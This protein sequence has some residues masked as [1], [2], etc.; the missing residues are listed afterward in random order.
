EGLRSAIRDLNPL[1]PTRIHRI[2][3]LARI[4]HDLRNP[5]RARNRFIHTLR[6]RHVH[7][8]GVA[9]AILAK[10]TRRTLD[11]VI[12]GRSERRKLD[13]TSV[14]AATRDFANVDGH[15]VRAVRVQDTLRLL[16]DILISPILGLGIARGWGR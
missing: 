7:E 2:G 1:P 3:D 6:P 16:R 5:E 8:S 14:R 13:D 11:S 9:Y 4:P 15:L 10:P 12:A